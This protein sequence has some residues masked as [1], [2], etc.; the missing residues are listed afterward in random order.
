MNRVLF[1]EVNG[2]VRGGAGKDRRFTLPERSAMLR[3]IRFGNHAYAAG[4]TT[5]LLPL[6]S[7]VRPTEPAAPAGG[8]RSGARKVLDLLSPRRLYLLTLLQ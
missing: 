6:G 1:L 2:A 7:D 3:S 5:Q 4:R 8:W